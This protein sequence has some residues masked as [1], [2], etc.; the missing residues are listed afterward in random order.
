MTEKWTYSAF[1]VVLEDALADV[2]AVGFDQVLRCDERRRRQGS[3][4]K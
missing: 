4:F 2:L 3:D 1:G